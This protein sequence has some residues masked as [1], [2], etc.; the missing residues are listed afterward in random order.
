M[1][2]QHLAD[3]ENTFNSLHFLSGLPH[4]KVLDL[5][6]RNYEDDGDIGSS[7]Y[8]LVESQSLRSLYLD[9]DYDGMH[10]MQDV[11]SLFSLCKIECL[12]IPADANFDIGMF[13]NLKRLLLY[14]NGYCKGVDFYGE[15]NIKPDNWLLCRI[16][17]S[18]FVYFSYIYLL[19]CH[20]SK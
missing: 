19:I 3:H 13:S 4:L 16:P 18:K 9:I 12:C 11:L 8:G 2:K 15:D 10:Y 7:E 14:D 6:L 17:V 5:N 20:T 1:V